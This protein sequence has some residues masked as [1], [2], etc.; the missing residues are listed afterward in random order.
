MNHPILSLTRTT[1]GLG[2]TVLALAGCASTTPALDASFGNAVREARAAQTLNPKASAQNTQPV[3]G[4]DGKA[5]N[6]AQGRYVDSFK[7][8]PKTFEVINIGGSITGE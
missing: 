3:L 7:T 2:A 8:P 4:I 1:L 5:A 6:E